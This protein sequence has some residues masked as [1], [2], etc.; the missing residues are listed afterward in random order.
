MALAGDRRA[1]LVTVLGSCFVAPLV[2]RRTFSNVAWVWCVACVALAGAR[3]LLNRPRPADETVESASAHRRTWLLLLFWASASLGRGPPLLLLDNPS[4]AI[5]L[6]GIFLAAAS[7]SAPLVVAWRSAVYLSLLP[8][9]APLL[10]TLTVGPLI[11]G[12]AASQ[13]LCCL[14]SLAAAFLLVLER[15]TDGAERFAR[16]A[17]GGAVSQ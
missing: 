4:A 3:L 11:G 16:V 7:L 10:M 12:P 5:L 14:R 8:A 15:L 2:E 1:V 17:A 13:I 9:L 6:T